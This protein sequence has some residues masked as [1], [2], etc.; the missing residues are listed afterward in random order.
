MKAFLFPGQGSQKVGMG[1]DLFDTYKRHVEIASDL[2]GYCLKTLCLE[3]PNGELGK[4]QYTQPA[5]YV[6]S[7]LAYLDRVGKENTK[8]DVLAGHSLGEY[9]A[10]FAAC[11]LF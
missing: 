7:A 3:D 1:A 4:T 10:L 6:V 5:L 9:N 2:L 8:P 11:K